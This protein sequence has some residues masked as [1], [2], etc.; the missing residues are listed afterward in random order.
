[1]SAHLSGEHCSTG[2]FSNIAPPTTS[3]EDNFSPSHPSFKGCGINW[4]VRFGFE[5]WLCCKTLIWKTKQHFPRTFWRRLNP[6]YSLLLEKRHVEP[7]PVAGLPGFSSGRRRWQKK[8]NVIQVGL[9]NLIGLGWAGKG[10]RWC[11]YNNDAVVL[12][13]FLYL[14]KATRCG[15]KPVE[16]R[17]EKRK[18]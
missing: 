11:V 8:S 12:Y 2:F 1:M 5:C 17:S 10:G 18:N 13:V 9:L 15:T 7:A 4:R 14:G 16:P 3:Y 6:F